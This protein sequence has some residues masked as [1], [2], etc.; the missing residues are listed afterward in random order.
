[1]LSKKRRRKIEL[2][3]R[4]ERVFR[5]AGNGGAISTCLHALDFSDALQ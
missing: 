1:M 4:I 3:K 5:L 2:L